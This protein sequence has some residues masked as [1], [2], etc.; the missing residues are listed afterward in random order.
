MLLT[1]KKEK[2]GE[3]PV[4][5]PLCPPQIPCGLT[6]QRTWAYMVGEEFSMVE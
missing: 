1:G 6:W 3:K 4:L 2:L 5:E